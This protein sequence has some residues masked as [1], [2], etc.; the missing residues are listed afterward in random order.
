MVVLNDK[1]SGKK[2]C[3][4]TEASVNEIIILSKQL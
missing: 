3:H 2:L 4:E 1:V